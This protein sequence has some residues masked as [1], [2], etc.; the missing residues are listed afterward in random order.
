MTIY[1]EWNVV[2]GA[3]RGSTSA[4]NGFPN[5]VE[6]WTSRVQ[7]VRVDQAVGVG[8]MG[9]ASASVL[10]DNS[11]G[12]FTPFGGG[13]YEDWD[14]LANP[15]WIFAKTGTNPASLTTQMFL[16]SG[17]VRDVRY[18]DDGFTSTVQLEV[19]DFLTLL[20]RSVITTNFNN[21]LSPDFIDEVLED[22]FSSSHTAALPLFEGTGSAYNMYP[23]PQRTSTDLAT[24]GV[25]RSY[26][27]QD[28]ELS[29]DI[30]EVVSDVAADILTS[31]HGVSFPIFMF[32]EFI[33]G[34]GGLPNV[35][36][37][38]FSH[39][40]IARNWL[41]PGSSQH[42]AP[43]EFSFVETTPTGTQLP[44]RDPTVGFNIDQLTN[45]ATCT[46]AGAGA[47]TQTADNSTSQASFGVRS[48]EFS[49]LTFGFD[50]D[51][52]ELAEHLV[53]RYDTV[54]YGVTGLTI[55][56]KMIEQK[57]ADAALTAVN[58]LVTMN[59]QAQLAQ[60]RGT[61]VITN[62]DDAVNGPLFHPAHV[63]FTGAG[64]VDLSSRVA[65]FRT[66]YTIT[67]TDWELTFS[68]GKPAV[69]TFGFVLGETHYGVLGT[70]RLA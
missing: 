20:A 33:L 45:K 30:G 68:D 4:P 3:W 9:Q 36:Q 60:P 17:M 29:A 32:C 57:C 16:F 15:L 64:N 70:N 10:L 40:Y 21:F 19:D 27:Y 49:G 58:Q 34:T 56:G 28:I 14:W 43:A 50:A 2:Q 6:D 26:L 18:T 31:G 63:D 22:L 23:T 53:S 69:S 65:F 37:N 41:W 46:I 48:A 47:V 12:V 44:F 51:A 35:L 67:P 54:T 38:Y 25:N 13:T 39:T 11:D 52:L 62:P 55:T 61:V 1:V 5:N 7:Q 24:A 42:N 66:S 8:T 59:H